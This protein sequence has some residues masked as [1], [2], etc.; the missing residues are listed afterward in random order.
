M[1]KEGWGDI[2]EHLQDMRQEELR[3]AE[4]ERQESGKLKEMLRQLY[5]V[6]VRTFVVIKNIIRFGTVYA[7]YY[8]LDINHA[9]ALS[10]FIVLI[11]FIQLGIDKLRQILNPGIVLSEWNIG[12]F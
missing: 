11:G 1:T 2:P 10:I 8:F 4:S 3:K 12:Y 5:R 6:C 7:C 9:I